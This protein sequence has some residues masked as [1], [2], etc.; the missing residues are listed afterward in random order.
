MCIRD[1]GTSGLNDFLRA[2]GS[3]CAVYVGGPEAQDRPALWVHGHAALGGTPIGNGVYVGVRSVSQAV[4]GVLD[5]KYRSMDFKFF[6][7]RHSEM[8][9]CPTKFQP[10]AC[11]RQVALKQC[12]QLPVP[13]WH[14]VLDLCGGELG[15]ISTTERE[16]RDDLK[17]QIVDEDDEES[18]FDEEEDDEDLF[19]SGV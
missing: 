17:F 15:E 14:Q 2:F 18:L 12:I 6:V 3:E 19:S 10:V 1:S 5:G 7:G 9:E 8:M 11:S 16:K 13:L 4:T